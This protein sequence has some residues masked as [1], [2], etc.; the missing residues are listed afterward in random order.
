LYTIFIRRENTVTGIQRY[1]RISAGLYS[2]RTEVF[3]TRCGIKFLL[4]TSRGVP[5]ECIRLKSCENAVITLTTPVC[6]YIT[7]GQQTDFHYI[8]YC[9][10]VTNSA[11]GQNRK[12]LRVATKQL[13]QVKTRSTRLELS[14]LNG[15][16]PNAL[17]QG[18]T[19]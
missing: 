19:K 1:T 17:G 18:Q 6:P 7:T 4:T 14:R 9:A 5:I 2:K 15:G 3:G 10:V 16:H 11:V 12:A 8:L 13:R